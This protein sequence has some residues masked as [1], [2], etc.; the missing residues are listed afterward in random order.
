M[1]DGSLSYDIFFKMDGKKSSQS[2]GDDQICYGIVGN[3]P[4]ELHSAD[5]RAFF[6]QFVEEKGFLCFHYRHRPEVQKDCKQK[7]STQNTKKTQTTCCCI[8]KLYKNKMDEFIK[9]YNGQNW[10]DKEGKLFT[11]K[12]L[13]SRIRMSCGSGECVHG[14]ISPQFVV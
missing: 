14:Q 9:M 2:V 12:A 6:S 4:A 3:I 1:A 5:V 7:D 11:Q 13:I 8:I 10:V